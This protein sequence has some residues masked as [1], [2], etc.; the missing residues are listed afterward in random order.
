[1]YADGHEISFYTKQFPDCDHVYKSKYVIFFKEPQLQY[2]FYSL[3]L[4]ELTAFLGSQNDFWLNKQ[5]EV[6]KRFLDLKN[7]QSTFQ[8]PKKKKRKRCG[9]E[10]PPCPSDEPFAKFAAQ[11]QIEF[12]CQCKDQ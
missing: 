1:M 11:L 12:F 3:T 6:E 4:I 2:F 9:K 10:P 5:K 8:E 7:G